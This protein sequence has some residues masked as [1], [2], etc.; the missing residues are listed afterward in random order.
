MGVTVATI[1]LPLRD[2]DWFEWNFS[3]V[4]DQ[5]M[6]L[7]CLMWFNKRFHGDVRDR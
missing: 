6:C 7:M 5:L 4:I 3:G 2:R 1:I